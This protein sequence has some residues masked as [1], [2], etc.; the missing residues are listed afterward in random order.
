MI[1]GAIRR[2]LK[3]LVELYYLDIRVIG[4]ERLPRRGP[5]IIVA[6]HP[7][8]IMDPLL[9][10]TRLSTKLSFLAR[11]GLF[12]N[13][14]IGAVL[15]WLG[16]I[17]VYRRQ[18]GP[19]PPGSNESAFAAAYALLR[20]AG[21]LGVFPEGKNAPERH[22]GELK[23]G[24]ARIALGAVREGFV[25]QVSIIPIGLNYEDRDR[26]LT[27][28]LVR[29][30]EP[31]EVDQ[32]MLA[33]DAVEK[34]NAQIRA[35][36]EGQ[37]THLDDIRHTDLLHQVATLIRS[38]RISIVGGPSDSELPGDNQ[39]HAAAATT[40]DFATYGAIA[41]ALN[42]YAASDPEVIEQVGRQLTRYK[43]NVKRLQLKFDFIH[44]T[45]QALSRR[46][47]AIKF[48]LTALSLYP[49]G[50]W[51]WFHHAPAFFVTRWFAL[52][53]P[54]DA[55]RAVRALGAASMLFPLSY[56]IIGAGLF[57][58]GLAPLWTLF[59][60]SILPYGFLIWLRAR[61]RME[62]LADRFLLRD[63]FIHRRKRYRQLL[64]ERE[65]LLARLDGLRRALPED[66]LN[67]RG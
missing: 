19:A 14:V 20:Q 64:L 34:L 59:Y 9:I 29:V 1:R 33:D 31:I 53:A 54:E 2:S 50:A 6:N 17:P 5:A 66:L 15:R 41:Q 7:N 60:L 55:M 67:R 51:G 47:E 61:T 8:S 52:R 49:I 56:L 28:V 23:T 13:P 10:S 44:R 58:F 39:A 37:I 32:D 22:L 48:S 46:R 45:P 21:V 27:D 36:I 57:A 24:A 62:K 30:G 65:A 3:A 26:Y 35:G 25:K 42:H 43:R 16:A 11:S 12:T 63:L 40:P 18:D 4:A 38:E